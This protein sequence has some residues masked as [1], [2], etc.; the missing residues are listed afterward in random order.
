MGRLNRP[1]E[2]VVWCRDCKVEKKRE[3]GVGV[4]VTLYRVY[5]RISGRIFFL[6]FL[7]QKISEMVIFLPVKQSHLD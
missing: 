1:D 6:F 7:K 2:L 3:S 5:R 4:F